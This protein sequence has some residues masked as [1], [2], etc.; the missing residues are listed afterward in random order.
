M[1]PFLMLLINGL[2]IQRDV[3]NRNAV[4]CNIINQK[5]FALSSS[6]SSDYSV[7]IQR[8]DKTALRFEKILNNSI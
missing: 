3:K 4:N 8:R 1:T 5:R 6:Y 2:R 7:Y